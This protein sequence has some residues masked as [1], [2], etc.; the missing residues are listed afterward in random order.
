MHRRS[1]VLTVFV[2]FALCAGPGAAGAARGAPVGR[3]SA[4]SVPA[5][6]LGTGFTY[7]GQ[8][9]NGS[10]PITGN[11]GMAFRL[12][13]DSAAGVLVGSPI[14]TSVPV[15]AGL[16][17][18][19]LDFGAGAFTGD[20][21]WLAIQVK[22]GADP[23]FTPLS[24]RQ[25]LSPAPL[26]LAL[27]GLYTRQNA[28]S[29][30]LIG[31]YAGNSV[32]LTAVGATI[33]GGGAVG[34]SNSAC[35]N[36]D[37]IGG[38][39][40]NTAI[41]SYAT[42]GGGL[43]NTAD[44][45]AAVGGGDG[46][47]ANANA[48]VSG[49]VSNTASGAGATVGGGASN[50]A[51]QPDATVDGGSINAAS[52]QYA[53]VGGGGNNTASGVGA[54][55]AGG[56]G[57][58]FSASFTNTASANWST[59]GGGAGNT[60]GDWFATVGGGQSNTASGAGATVG[61][62]YQNIAGGAGATVAGGGTDGSTYAGNMA[63]GAASTI[64]GGLGNVVTTTAQYATVGGGLHNASS[65]FGTVI[66]GG[67]YNTASFWYATISGGD[68][69]LA[70]GDHATI[71]GGGFNN[72]PGKYATVPG[73][74]DNYAPGQ[75]SFAA[76]LKAKALNDGAF[77]WADHIGLDLNSTANDQFL[78]RATGGISMATNSTLTTGCSIPAGGGA[79]NCTSDRNAKA[80]F[81]SVDGLD[82]LNRL[83]GIPIQTWNF[84]TQDTTIRHMGPMAQDFA[85]AFHVGEN[86]TTISTVDA[87]GVALA[88]IQGLYRLV[89]DQSAQLTQ[90]QAEQSAEQAQ[91]EDL[92]ARLSALEHRAPGDAPNSSSPLSLGWLL[93]GGL[94]LLNLGGLLGYWLARRRH[95]SGGVA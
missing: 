88:A 70:S 75:Y 50:T 73:G 3:D 79:W 22:C 49:G 69:N 1:V 23:V 27:P 13:D 63:L 45:F 37:T 51:S 95:S 9:K 30:N 91:I 84:K 21:R 82:I 36:F 14:T 2:L 19:P 29:P 65:Y 15:T 77:V 46:N 38:G 67:G 59:I 18:V 68:S 34:Q 64:A 81:A 6:A 74:L 25:P 66:G 44:S 80:N 26:A 92:H 87:Q 58:Y 16:F 8:L 4:A 40:N 93:F 12:Y 57:S 41:D 43:G 35:C 17:T 5:A 61:G 47:L 78:V 11:C 56:G 7:Q 72:V 86:D 28:T 94:L 31:G 89:K 32:G 54:V 48:T 20:A 10:G 83:M 33:G 55:V 90:L 71:G 62:G 53:T 85:A 52:G 24:P 60:A 42:I 76:G 39:K